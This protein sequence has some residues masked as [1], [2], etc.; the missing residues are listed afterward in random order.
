MSVQSKEEARHDWGFFFFFPLEE[1]EWQLGKV[2]IRKSDLFIMQIS[3]NL[4][5]ML[6]K[7]CIH[8]V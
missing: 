6:A 1:V 3:R 7:S 4:F 2:L 8:I 5:G